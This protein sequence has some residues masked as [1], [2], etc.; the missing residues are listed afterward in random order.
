MRYIFIVFVFT[1]LGC[2]KGF[3]TENPS[4]EF[5]TADNLEKISGL[6]KDT[7]LMG[8]TPVLGEISSDDYFLNA[9]R[10][11]ELFGYEKNACIWDADIFKG[12]E[13]IPD[14]NLLYKQIHY[15]NVVIEKLAAI[16]RD[17]YPYQQ[18]Q[19]KETRGAALFMRAFAI[20]NLTQ[21]FTTPYDKDKASDELGIPLPLSSDISK[22]PDRS[23]MQVCYDEAIN[24]LKEAAE[25]LPETI[26]PTSRSMP[27][28]PAAYAL[29]ARI[30]L[31]QRNYTDALIYA[32]KCLDIH[33]DLIDFNKLD[34]NQRFPVGALN[35]ETLYKT[36]MISASNVI[37]GRVM[38]E[39]VIDSGLF[40]LYDRDDLRKE[41]FFMT[42]AKKQPIFKSNYSGKSL[43]FSGLATDEMFLVQAECNA[44]QGLIGKAME[45]INLLL[46]NRYKTGTLIRRQAFSIEEALD[47]ILKERRKELVFRGLRWL[48]LRRLNQ[49]DANIILTR[50]GEGNIYQLLPG[51]KK[52]ALPF[53]PDALRGTAIIQNERE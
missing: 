41:A 48:D 20:F 42:N 13:N 39:T 17:I 9:G 23:T 3:L 27:N 50:M 19:W 10:F 36:W 45:D 35:V 43:A 47:I 46:E 6:L 14:F 24:D 15:C 34:Y 31:S 33:K 29:L 18:P 28:K 40:K 26:S 11:K 21:I 4:S 12:E 8:E 37:Q 53:P 38:S 30:F 25:L 16:K 1:C 44:R 49:E 2:K 52:Y 5:I 32:G 51:S 7:L 22:V